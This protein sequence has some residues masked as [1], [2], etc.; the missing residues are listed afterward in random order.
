[1]DSLLAS[2]A[3][4]DEEQEDKPQ[5]S[6]PKSAGFLSS[7]PPPKSSSSSSSSSIS[8][9]LPPPQSHPPKPPVSSSSSTLNPHKSNVLQEEEDGQQLLITPESSG[10][11]AS[12][13]KPS[14]SLF[15]SLPQPKSSSTSS[16]FSSLPQPTKTLNPDARAPPPAQSAGKRV[17]QFK[18]PPVYSSTNVGNEDDDEDD[19]DDE[20]QEQKKQPVVQTASVKSFLSSIPAP[21][22]SATLGALPSASGS[23]RRSTIDADVPGLKDSKVVNAAS[24]SEAG[25]STSSI[26]YYEGQSSNDQM[27][28]SSG[29]DLSNSSGYANGGGDYSSWGHGSENYANHAGYGAYENNGGSG[30]AGDYQNWDGGNGDSV[31]YSGDYGSYA[32]YGQYENN[33]ADVPTAA[34]GP[35]V[36]GFA[37]NALRV[38][39]KR[40]RNNAPEEIVEVKQDELMKNRP[41]EDQ[42]KL[43]GIAFGPAYQPTSTKGKPSKLHKR[44]HQIG[45]L[46]F[47]MKQKEME[48]S[49][50]RAR[51]FLTKAQTQGKYGW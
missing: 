41:R 3:S 39:G 51:G 49:E 38:S 37:E 20:E 43:T 2:Y 17:V 27:S 24:G 45:S 4:S 8:F 9:P 12:L 32:N 36:S 48:L 16:L 33:W 25:V 28:M 10:L 14:S 13:P 1:M 5:L 11:L 23:G 26:G 42:V 44:K 6:N 29:G 40:G 22:N 30:V 35:E 21:R 31:N 19:D 15:A 46:F 50:R 34:V 18:P 7:L 47:D